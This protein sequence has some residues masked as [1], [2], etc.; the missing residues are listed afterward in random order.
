MQ[1]T[2]A[3]KGCAFEADE[4]PDDCPVCGHPFIQTD[5]VDYNVLTKDSLI[6]ELKERDLEP[7]GDDPP[8]SRWSK[9]ELIGALRFDDDTELDLGED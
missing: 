2:C 3:Q 9:D 6:D 4:T 7:T 1:F 8:F 5:S